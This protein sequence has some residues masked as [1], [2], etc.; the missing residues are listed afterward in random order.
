MAKAKNI[1]V[2]LTLK[3]SIPETYNINSQAFAPLKTWCTNIVKQKV[4]DYYQ[5]S[6]MSNADSAHNA[7]VD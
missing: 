5:A 6:D 4:F 3:D 2:R 7:S 1:S